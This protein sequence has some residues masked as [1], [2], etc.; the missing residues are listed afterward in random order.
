MPK[1]YKVLDA[2]RC[3]CHGGSGEWVVGEW[4]EVGG[5]LVPCNNGLHLCKDVRQLVEWLGPTIWEAEHDGECVDAG[6]KI[7][8]RRARIVRQLPWTDRTARLFACDCAERVLPI[9]ERECPGDNRPRRA[10][11]V[12]RLYAEGKAT[13]EEL[14]AASAA[15]SDAARAA[16]SDAA[17]AAARDAQ[18]CDLARYLGPEASDAN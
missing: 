14:A 9:Y 6:D 13:D 8:V 7:V 2:N 3:S 1:A 16:A 15:A 12:A 17:W 4:R 18:V 10:V 11:D 5:D